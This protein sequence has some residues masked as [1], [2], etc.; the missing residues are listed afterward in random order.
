[1]EAP[2]LST[3]YRYSDTHTHC[4]ICEQLGYVHQ[5]AITL[6]GHFPTDGQSQL[7]LQEALT[8]EKLCR[9]FVVLPS[10]IR[11]LVRLQH[12]RAAAAHR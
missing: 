1:M 10:H 9:D 2:A 6:L 4:C 8:T 12:L 3:F 11:V 7:A 5:Y